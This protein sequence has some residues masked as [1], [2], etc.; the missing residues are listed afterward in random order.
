M[1]GQSNSSYQIF[2]A[3][4]TLMVLTLLFLC[5]PPTMTTLGLFPSAIEPMSIL[6]EV[7]PTLTTTAIVSYV[8]EHIA[9]H[10]C[11]GR[12]PFKCFL[13]RC[14]QL[15]VLNFFS[16]MDDWRFICIPKHVCKLKTKSSSILFIDNSI[17]FSRLQCSSQNCWHS[18]YAIITEVENQKSQKISKVLLPWLVPP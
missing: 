12:K 16:K 17:R 11:L 14:D 5:P 4:S 18:S 15:S 1:N 13:D 2:L 6:H 8:G 10:P 7:I 3:V 9:G